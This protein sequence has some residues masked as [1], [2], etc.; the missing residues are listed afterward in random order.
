MED[1]QP[2][3]NLPPS[4]TR[5]K[6]IDDAVK[7]EYIIDG[8]V[9]SILGI[10]FGT[11]LSVGN[12]SSALSFLQKINL[13]FDLNIVK[14]EHK[15]KFVCLAEIRNQFA[16]DLYTRNMSECK[17]DYIKKL[18]KF[19]P[20]LAKLSTPQYDQLY[21]SL[22]T[23]V[24]NY[25]ITLFELLKN[26]AEDKGAMLGKVKFYEIFMGIASEQAKVNPAF[27]IQFEQI[28]QKTQHIFESQDLEEGEANIPIL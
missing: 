20:T 17:I 19:Y 2:I 25:S 7:I 4:S 13:L 21:E 5:A 11:P 18:N 10:G 16:H 27:E 3:F 6:V 8:I 9:A 23:D 14:E 28:W 22:I 1:L 24:T 12:K 15:P 26:K